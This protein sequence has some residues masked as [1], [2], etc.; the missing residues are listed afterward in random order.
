MMR[1]VKGLTV[2]LM[3]LVMTASIFAACTNVNPKSFTVSF[4]ANGGTLL[5]STSSV[6]VD[7]GGALSAD[8]LLT[9]TFTGY[10]FSGWFDA[11]TSGTK[12]VGGEL[13]SANL[14]LYAQWTAKIDTAFSVEYYFQNITDDN[15]IK[16][17]SKT[18]NLSGT[19]DTT[20][21]ITAAAVT[22][23][24]AQTITQANIDGDGSAVVSVYYNRNSY[25]IT[26]SLM[27]GAT[28]NDSG[29]TSY[30]FGS[31]YTFLGAELNGYTFNGWYDAETG[32]NRV[33]EIS[34]TQTGALTLYAD[35][36]ANV[37]TAYGSVL[38][39]SFVI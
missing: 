3:V 5:G 25:E 21:S 31:T 8:S 20:T 29:K 24:T 33:E 32:G 7:D 38:N 14:T 37:G 16:D 19:T 6:T 36:T 2:V 1:R 22:G 34:A 9:A 35:I 26:Y 23:F 18:Q 28:N 13:I 17:T 10:D 11:K 12:F 30:K 4:D 15:Y 39:R 27:T